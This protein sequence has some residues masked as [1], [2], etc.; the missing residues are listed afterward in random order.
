MLN[1]Q[2]NVIGVFWWFPE[3]NESK[4]P[5]LKGWINRGL[6]DN[7]IGKALPAFYEFIKYKK[8]LP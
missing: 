3:E 8:N 5:V 4:Y 1:K 2:H 6:F 7:N